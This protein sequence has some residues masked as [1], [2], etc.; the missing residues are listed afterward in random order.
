MGAEWQFSL[1]GAKEALG[2]VTGSALLSSRLQTKLL[3]RELYCFSSCL[4]LLREK[5]RVSTC[6]SQGHLGQLNLGATE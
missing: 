5:G 6:H 2:E 1:F 3:M 4:S